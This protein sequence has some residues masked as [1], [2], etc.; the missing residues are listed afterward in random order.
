MNSHEPPHGIAQFTRRNFLKI[1]AAVGAGFTTVFQSACSHLPLGRKPSSTTVKI[2]FEKEEITLHLPEGWRLLDTVKPVD[3][4]KIADIPGALAQAL[5][6]PIGGGGALGSRDLSRKRIVLCVEDVSRPTQTAKFFGPLLDY[7]LAHGAQPKNML[8][9]FALGSHR[10]MTE[11]EARQKLGKVDLRGVRWVNHSFTDESQLKHVGTTLRGT[12][13]SINKHLTEADLII[14]VGAIEPHL[15]LGFSGGCKMIIPGLASARTIGENHMQGVSGQKYNYVGHPESPM[16]LDL[17]EGA[18]LIGK[19]IF[20]V[21]AVNNDALE[22]CAFFAGHPVKAH[23]AGVKFS[24]SLAERPVKQQADVVIVASSPM[25]GDLRQSMKCVG[26]V[27]ESVR[28]GGLILGF[29][30]CR[31]GIG[32]VTVPPKT[33]PHGMLRGL[34]KIVGQ[35]NLLGFLD[36]VRKDAAIEERF[37]SHFSAQLTLR[38]EI[39]VYSRK[40]PS[41]TGKKLGIFVQFDSVEKMME[42]ARRKAPRDATVLVFPFGGA[43]YPRVEG[44][45]T[46]NA[47]R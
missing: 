42:A 29:I 40:L 14:T 27:Q 2:P 30:E 38:N 13:V 37:L 11:D 43:T 47:E 4:E 39:F 6:N 44:A 46:A 21:N 7:L 24:Q 5:D 33:L 16:R 18:H 9:L 1:C 32:D 15:L 12:Y 31:H 20:I 23:R 34:F 8:V 10:D 45:E 35:N 22:V 41:D 28:P 17:E 36:R 26:N 3:R 25:N 19:E